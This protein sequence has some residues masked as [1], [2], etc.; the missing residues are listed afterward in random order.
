MNEQLYAQWLKAKPVVKSSTFF[1][2]V[3]MLIAVALAWALTYRYL[4]E[5]WL[6]IGPLDFVLVI[7][8]VVNVIQNLVFWI[9]NYKEFRRAWLPLFLNVLTVLIPF[10][11][12]SY[13]YNKDHPHGTTALSPVCRCKPQLYLARYTVYAQG[14][15][16]ADLDGVYLTDQKNFRVFVTTVDQADESVS[17]ICNGDKLFVTKYSSAGGDTY[18]EEPRKIKEYTFSLKKLIAAH[19][20]E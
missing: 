16:G 19:R 5:A 12:P 1:W 4:G 10:C 7:I 20:F 3:F 18:K 9:G 17:I 14:A 13:V 11:T 6:I 15:W 2:A 8:L